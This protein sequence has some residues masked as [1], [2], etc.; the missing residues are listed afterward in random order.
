MAQRRPNIILINCD[1]L[2]YGDL[3]CY[4]SPVNQS[5]A[6]DALAAR[7]IRLTDFYMASPVCSPSRGG[8]LTGCYPARIGFGSFD[9]DLVLFPGVGLGLAPDEHTVAA[10]LRDLGYA[11]MLVGKWH[12]GD[13]PGF[14]PN[15][16]GFD[17]F[18]GLPYSNDMGRQAGA[19]RDFPPLPLM[20]DDAILQQQPDQAALTERYTAEC[21]RFIRE[22]REEPFFL[23]LAHMY[24][25]A[26]IYAPERFLRES[27][28]GPY[29]A[30][31]ACVDWSTSVLMSE[32]AA[33]GLD[34]DTLVVFTS[35][36]GSRA[37]SG[38]SNAPLPAPRAPRGRAASGCRASCRGPPPSPAVRCAGTWSP[39][40]TCCRRSWSWPADHLRTALRPEVRPRTALRLASRLTA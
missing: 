16:H 35:D 17:R 4:G 25:H 7:G 11:T 12:C 38:A 30:A 18:F 5:P 40:W 13:Q 39:R 10:R 37:H 36:N 1:D 26:P 29:G 32:L 22:H 34:E 21:V 19:D 9:G 20:L 14:L 31:V 27:S 15:D 33:L 24:V 23:Y 28:N 6:I 3:G 8:M 2:G